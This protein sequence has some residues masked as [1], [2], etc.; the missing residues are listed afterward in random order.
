M[1]S[2]DPV[3]FVYQCTDVSGGKNVLAKGQKTALFEFF[4]F[5]YDPHWDDLP[6]RDTQ[7]AMRVT[8][9]YGHLPAMAPQLAIY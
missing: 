9:S 2:V 3:I 4:S 8:E 7:A 1:G 5:G 6:S